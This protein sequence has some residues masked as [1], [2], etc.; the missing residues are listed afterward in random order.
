MLALGQRRLFDSPQ[1]MIDLDYYP[2]LAS[3]SLWR[4]VWG[5]EE[6]V[7]L[8]FHSDAYGHLVRVQLVH[9]LLPRDRGTLQPAGV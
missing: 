4:S 6:N 9:E 1:T 8:I 5:S 3:R 2:E 7:R